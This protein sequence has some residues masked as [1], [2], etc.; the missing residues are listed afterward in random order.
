MGIHIS[1]LRHFVGGTVLQIQ[2]GLFIDTFNEDLAKVTP[3]IINSLQFVAIV[4]GILYLQKVF[5]KRQLFSFSLMAL[6]LMNFAMV[7]AMIFE[8]ILAVLLLMC[9][10]MLLFGSSFINL[11]WA[12]PA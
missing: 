9:L 3:I 10:F 1:A 11:T 6:S 7:I 12:Y 5:G 8:E 4:F 2:G